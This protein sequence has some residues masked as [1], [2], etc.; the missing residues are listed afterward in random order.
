MFHEQMT[1]ESVLLNEVKKIHQKVISL[2]KEDF[3]TNSLTKLPH[4]SCAN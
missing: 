3:T 2:F 4:L 1:Y